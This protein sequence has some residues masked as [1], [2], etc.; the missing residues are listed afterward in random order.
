MAKA[1]SHLAALFAKIFNRVKFWVA[2]QSKMRSLEQTTSE[3]EKLRAENKIC[4]EILATATCLNCGEPTKIGEIISLDEHHMRDENARLREEVDRLSAIT[5]MYEGGPFLHYSHIIPYFP[6]RPQ[7]LDVDYFGDTYGVDDDGDLPRSISGPSQANRPSS[8]TELVAEAME[9]LIGMAQMNEPLWFTSQDGTCNVLNEDAYMRCF[10]RGVIGPK[11]AGFKCEASRETTVVN[12]NPVNL[13]E[14]LMDVNLWSRVFRGIVS[15]AMTL[16][17]LSTGVTGSYNGALQAMKAEFQ[18]PSPLVATRESNFVRYCKQHSDGTWAVVDVSVD[19]LA[20]CRRRPSGCLI[21]ESPNGY[22]K[23]TWVEHMEV[24]D[25]GV[26]D[27]LYKQLVNSGIAFGA[28]RWVATLEREC[29][30]LASFMETNIPTTN[31][32][33][34]IVSQEQRKRLLKL[35]ERMMIGFCRGVSASNANTWTTLA[36]DVRVM[37]RQNVED[38]GSPPGLVIHA[39]TSFWLPLPPKRVFDVLNDLNSKS[40]QQWRQKPQWHL[41]SLHR[42]ATTTSITILSSSFTATQFTVKPPPPPLTNLFSYFMFWDFLAYE[43]VVQILGQVTCGGERGNCVSLLRV[44]NDTMEIQESCTDATGSFIIYTPI[45][46]GVMDYVLN[47]GDPNSVVTFPSGIAI[48]PD[49]T[50]T[51]G[52]DIGETGPGGSLL[53]VAFQVLAD[54]DPTVEL[55]NGFLAPIINLVSVTVDDIRTSISPLLQV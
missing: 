36:N 47:G 11:P 3:I 52:N 39:A 50:T 10:P 34:V 9:V 6:S 33:G 20:T 49:G 31:V 37:L 46:I 26:D 18:V 25:R 14:I 16:E 13:V 54:A 5:A 30:R 41:Y 1:S 55:S 4:K 22:S 32:V 48:L 23:V 21:Q 53:T 35:A 8:M 29:E 45:D 2:K 38:P 27:N 24:D 51:N 40:K 28:K 43:R 17:V 15:S 42:R 12:M 19:P 7:E 44:N